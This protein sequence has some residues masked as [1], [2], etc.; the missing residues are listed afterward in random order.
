MNKILYLIYLLLHLKRKIME[1]KES[2]HMR[3]NKHETELSLP[4]LQTET[5]NQEKEIDECHFEMDEIVTML[6]SAETRK[7]SI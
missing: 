5:K 3:K 2:I 4:K 6:L 1:K 7:K